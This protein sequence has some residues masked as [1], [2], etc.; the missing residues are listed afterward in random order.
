[1]NTDVQHEACGALRTLTSDN[2]HNKVIAGK[3]QLLADLQ[4]TISTH[5]ANIKILKETCGAVWIMVAGN[6]DNRKWAGE[7]YL[8]A[9]LQRVMRRYVHEAELQRQL[10]F[11]VMHILMH[12]QDNKMQAGIIGLIQ[13]F[14]AVADALTDE[15]AL[16]AVCDAVSEA[17]HH[18]HENKVLARDCG[19]LETVKRMQ[20]FAESEMLSRSATYA[21]MHM[22]LYEGKPP[23]ISISLPQLQISPGSGAPSQDSAKGLSSLMSP[24][25]DLQ[26]RRAI[27]KISAVQ[28]MH[29]AIS[30]RKPV[31]GNSPRS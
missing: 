25:S 28:R 17:C 5:M 2:A 24:R 6:K 8:L 14:K 23:K 12:E 4:A 18:C 19:L 27:G 1:M 13:D 31:D 9:D 20:D 16:S 30:P 7:N 21:Y 29:A 26:W 22:K 11:A 10:A 3:I 15:E